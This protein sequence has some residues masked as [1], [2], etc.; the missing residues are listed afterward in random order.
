VVEL[1]SATVSATA[2]IQVT[3][4][5]VTRTA[6][7]AFEALT[8]EQVYE[9]VLS[10]TSVPAD[11]L[12]TTLITVI[13]KRL[14]TLPQRAVKLDVA[15]AFVSAGQPNSRPDDYCRPD[16]ARGG[17]TSQRRHRGIARVA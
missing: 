2:Q 13:L 6:S 8:R 4:A 3:V 15:G 17:G 10:A 9:V 1:R 7:I 14:G 5:S 16:R 12:S 11:D